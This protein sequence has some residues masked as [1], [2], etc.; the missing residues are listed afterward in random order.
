MEFFEI[1]ESN[2]IFKGCDFVVQLGAER[3][4]TNIK[5]LQ[6]TDTQII[7]SM[8][9]R[10]PDR[11][12]P[13]EI[14]AWDPQDFDAQCGDHIR[15]LVAQARPDLIFITG[16]L[17]Y[18]SFDDNGT[19]LEYFCALMDSFEIPWAPVWGNHDNES[20]KGI[21]WQCKQLENSKYCLFKKGAVSG[22]SNYSVGIA[23]GN[24]LVRVLHMVDS[25]GCRRGNEGEVIK[26]RGIYP[27]QLALIEENTSKIA[28][29]QGRA[30][31]AFMAFHYPVDCF[32][33]AEIAKGY[34]TENRQAY[35]LGVD[36][37]PADGDFGFSL[38]KYDR[39]DTDGNFIEFIK[40]Q[41]I[42]GVFVGHVHKNT[43]SISY[44]NVRWTFGLKSGQY[45][46]HVAGSLGGTLVTLTGDDFTVTH[47]PSLVPFAPM[48]SKAKMFEKFFT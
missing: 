39:V 35:V 33:E 38:E 22:N 27:D 44:K 10:T 9:M 23:V 5:L 48:P 28:E 24:K 16:D 47:I 13:D 31:P 45:D 42:D 3:K 1:K 17:V 30:V 46:Y 37:A 21:V 8:Q 40:K 34:K 26:Q 7:D 36:V 25:N 11:L 20:A 2:R 14:S 18:G 43:T 32:E 6:I 41:N 4:D 12:R 29:A 15:S 19:T